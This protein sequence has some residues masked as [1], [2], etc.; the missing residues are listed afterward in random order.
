MGT[1]DDQTGILLD[2]GTNELEVLVFRMAGCVC[3]VNVAK[4]R[5]VVRWITPTKTPHLHPSV[6]GMFKL[7]GEVIA[8]VEL[9]R[10]LGL[11]A[12]AQQNEDR[13]VIVTEFNGRRTAFAIDSVDQIHRVSW[14]AIEP[15]P[16]LA[17]LAADQ[18]AAINACTGVLRMGEELILMLDFESVA[19]AIAYDERLHPTAIAPPPAGLDRSAV[20]VLVAEDSPF[21]RARLADALSQAGYGT[22]DLCPD[23]QA[24][25]E[26]LSAMGGQDP[27]YDAI[28]ADIEMPRMDGL[29]LTRRIKADA[30]TAR[31]PVVLFSSLVTDDNR[32]KGEQVGA[33]AQV[34]KPE[35]DRVVALID[36]FAQQAKAE[37]A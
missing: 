35:L 31:T 18:R 26:K 10:H 20:R 34:S 22:V 13:R 37:A 14:Q 32:K 2:A 12:T 28:L 23:G 8:L 6:E 4:V 1:H 15:V 5:E 27:P 19:D 29:H 30:R 7:R 17:S 36:G 11:E 16:D 25:W 21:M 33:D 3:G 24:A 9:A